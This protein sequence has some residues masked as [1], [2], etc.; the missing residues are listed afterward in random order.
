MSTHSLELVMA[1][2]LLLKV[3]ALAEDV[4]VGQELGIIS[5]H[6]LKVQDLAEIL[7]VDHRWVRVK[8]TTLNPKWRCR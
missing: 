4:R 3:Q 6:L 1:M 2:T 5:A 8:A 7:R